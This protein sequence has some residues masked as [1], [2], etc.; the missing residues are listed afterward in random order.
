MRDNHGKIIVYT[1][2]GLGQDLTNEE[3]ARLHQLFYTKHWTRNTRYMD[4]RESALHERY[5]AMINANRE[6]PRR[7]EAREMNDVSFTFDRS[8]SPMLQQN[9]SFQSKEQQ[10]NRLWKISE[11]IAA[12]SKPTPAPI[13]YMSDGYVPPAW[14]TY[15]PSICSS[16]YLPPCMLASKP[17]PQ[18]S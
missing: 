13:L 5:E 6:T 8:P 11:A 16:I 3:R 14:A 12:P 2:T 7:P 9:D 15:M 1:R 18:L 4:F 10:N 17:S